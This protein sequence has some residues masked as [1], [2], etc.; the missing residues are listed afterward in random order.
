MKIDARLK[1]YWVAV[2][3]L[4]KAT[5]PEQRMYWLTGPFKLSI[6]LEK[7]PRLKEKLLSIYHHETPSRPS[8]GSFHLRNSS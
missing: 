2:L 7:D 3:G 6:T 4:R 5:T 1:N 8:P